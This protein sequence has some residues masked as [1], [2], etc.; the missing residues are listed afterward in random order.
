[1]N[2]AYFRT[3]LSAIVFLLS[4]Y[5]SVMISQIDMPAASPLF[6]VVGKIG[7]TEVK[8]D[9]SRPS[10]RG[11]EVFGNIVPFN[12]VWRTG[13]NASTKISFS[14]DVKLNGHPVEAGTYALYSMFQEDSVT[15][16]LHSN[17][18]LYGVLGYNEKEDYLRFKVKVKHPSSHYETMT[19]SFSDFTKQSA[20]FNLKWEHTK[21]MFLIETEVDT[22]VMADIKEKL[23]NDEGASI[24]T[25][26]QA[27][28]Y[29]FQNDKDLNQ[30]LEW[31][32]IAVDRSDNVQYWVLHLRA[33]IN[34]ALGH[35]AASMEDAQRS[36]DHAK[37]GGNM[38]YVRLNQALLEKLK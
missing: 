12:E 7:L 1:M 31:V 22:Y 33:K 11:R 17:L 38:D 2:R 19:V 4:Y 16:I 26:F 20:H 34:H 14:K 36:L 23:I 9:Y 13:A 3:S 5:N 10:A 28:Q 27:A 25:Y 21:M 6:S 29:Y 8:V 24:E 18:D 37:R 30:A 32:T 35:D 15:V